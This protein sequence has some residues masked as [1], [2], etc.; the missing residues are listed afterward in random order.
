MWTGLTSLALG[1]TSFAVHLCF[2]HGPATAEP[3]AIGPFIR[4]HPSYGAVL[5]LC[6]AGLGA[7]SISKRQPPVGTNSDS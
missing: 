5:L 7:R 2:G 6:L 3:M 1:V 4:V